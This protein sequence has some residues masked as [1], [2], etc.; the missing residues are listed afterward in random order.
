MRFHY[1]ARK[2]T[3]A[4]AYLVRLNGGRMDLW[5]MLKLLYLS[6]RASLVARGTPITA[7]ELASMPLGPTPSQIYDNTKADRNP[8]G[9]DS[10]WKEYLTENQGGNEIRLINDDFPTE[11]LSQFERGIIQ[12]TWEKFAKMPWPAL[13]EFLHKLPEYTD[14]KGSS[15]LINPEDILKNAKWADED[16]EDSNRNAARERYLRIICK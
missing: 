1:N 13:S 12:Q 15:L 9:K 5:R 16:I 2:A 6:D 4:A 11:Q 14:P 7:D 10:V 3:Q 8:L